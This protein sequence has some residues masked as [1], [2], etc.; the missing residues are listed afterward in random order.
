MVQLICCKDSTTGEYTEIPD[1]VYCGVS[2]LGPPSSCSTFTTAFALQWTGSGWASADNNSFQIKISIIECQAHS[3]MVFF[4]CRSSFKEEGGETCEVL[5]E[6]AGAS[7]FNFVVGFSAM[8]VS[9]NCC[10][11]IATYSIDG[12]VTPPPF[13]E[14][15]PFPP[16]CIPGPEVCCPPPGEG[17]NGGGEGGGG[18][19]GGNG[20]GGCGGFICTPA[21]RT[22][23]SA[24]VRYATGEMAINV[25]DLS[26]DGYGVPWGHTR[27]FANRQTASQ[28]IGNGFNWLVKEWPYL[29]KKFSIQDSGI[30]ID[31][32]V[33]QG[34][35]G[36]ALW[37]DNVG[38]NVFTPRFNVKDTFIHHES[39]NLYKLYKQDGSV[40]EF[41]DTT[42]M[43][44]RQTDPAGNKIEVTAMSVNSYN[45]TEVERTYTADGSTTNEQFLYNYDNSLGDY[46]LKDLT[47]R[48][49]VDTGSWTNISKVVYT[50]YGYDSLHGGWEDLETVTTQQWVNG[51]WNDTGT[52]YYRYYLEL[53]S[54]N[55]SSSSSSLSSSG[56][57]I[58]SPT[59]VRLL[60]Y[61]VEPAAYT[62]MEDDGVNPLTAS[63]AQ[64]ALYANYYFEYDA[65]RRVTKEMV[66][67]AS[68]TYL[69]SYEESGFSD[70]VNSWKTKTTE[71]LPD[72]SQNIIFSNS[73]GQTMLSV[74]KSGS[75][76]WNQFNKY[77]DTNQIVLIAN[78]SAITGYDETKADLLNEQAGNYQYMKDNDGL[79]HTFTYD[80]NSGFQTSD[81]IQKGELG[82]SIK[83]LEREYI[84]CGSD[85]SSSSSSSS[86]SGLAYFLSKEILYPS[87]TDQTKKIITSYAY[88]WYEGTCQV[89]EKTTTLPVIST[90]QNGSGVANTR[91]EYFDEY[92][93]LTWT[94]DERGYI[95]QSVYDIP[96]GALTQLVQ[97]VDTG[98]ASG[99]PTGWL[100]P[101][102][103]GLNLVT[104]F[105]HDDRGH[106]TQSLGPAHTIDLEGVATEI[107]TANW[108]V[109]KS[110]A[111]E[112]Q[113]T[114]A[115][116]YATGTLPSYTYTLINPVSISKTDKYGNSLERIQAT[117]ASTSGKLL[118]TDT[119][120][121]SSYVS[122]TTNQYT[123][124]CLLES[125]RAYH[126]IPASGTGSSGTNYD[127][128]DFGYD[129][130]KRQNRTRT[131]GGTI[132]F[133]VLDVRGNV[134]KT[135]I[136]TDDT[137]ATN[138]DPTG[139]GAVG[140]NM[141][142]VTELEY[143]GGTAGGDNNL[144]KQTQ[145]ASAS[146]TRITSFT[147]DW[148]NRNT[149][150]DGE[151]DHFQKKYY[152]NLNR[153]TKTELYNTTSAGNLI[154]RS[155]TKFDDL[156]RV[157]RTV[158]YGVDPSTGTVGNSLTS[159]TWYDA[160]GNVIKQLSA[161]SDLFIKK[162]YDSVG[163]VTNQ[164][165][166]YDLNET[167]YSDTSNVT[168]DTIIEQT[169][170]YYDDA[171]NVIKNITRQR[172][173]NAP[174][175]QKGEL[176]NPATTPKAR[177]N[178][179]AN[180][181]DGIGRSIVSANYGT[182]GGTTLSRSNTIPARSDNVLVVTQ[183]YNNAG[184][185]AR[186]TNPAGLVNKYEFDNIGRQTSVI[187]NYNEEISSSS[188]SSGGCEPSDEVNRTTRYTYTEDG[189]ESTIV[190]V[191]SI[192]GN[193]TTVYSYGI[194][195]SDSDIAMNTI[196]KSISY[197]DSTGGSDVVSY[198]YNRQQE[199][200]TIT[201]QRNCIHTFEYD[202]LGRLI[203]DRVTTTGTGVDDAVLRRSI[204]YDV[205]GL[206][207][208]LTTYDN[209]TVA[210][211]NIVNEIEN[212]FN[213]FG[214]LIESR[215]SHS[216][217]VTGLSPKVV[218]SYADGSN[219]TIRQTGIKY[220][221]GRELTYSYGLSG[222]MAD[223][224]SRAIKLIDDDLTT[225]IE[226]DYLGL[227]TFVVADDKEPDIK[228]TLVDLSS[229]NDVDTGDI[230]SGLD[231]FGRIKDCRWYDSGSSAD[232]VRIKYGH[233]RSSN[234]LWQ[235][236]I[237]AQTYNQNYDELFSYDGLNRLQAMRR[238]LLNN[239][240]S[241]M[242]TQDYDQC[243]GMDSTENWVT[244]KQ[245]NGGSTWTL[246]QNRI[247]NKV[248]EITNIS[249]T[250]GV[251][252][253]NPVFD[254]TGNM[255]TIPQSA[256]PG[257]SYTATWDAWDHLVKLVDDDTDNP[258]GEY[259]YDALGRRIVKQLFSSGV[260]DKTCHI[261]LSPTWQTVEERVDASSAPERQLVW[262]LQYIDDLVLRDRDTIGNGTLDERIYASYDANWNIVGLSNTNGS[263][264]Q[265]FAY[266]PYGKSNT[267]STNFTVVSDS[268]E[269]RY[270]FTSREGDS[271]SSL[272]YFRERYYH[273]QLGQFINRDPIEYQ[274]GN[275]L[276]AA[277][278]V[279]NKTD[280]F[281][282]SS[283][284]EIVSGFF[285]V[286]QGYARAG[287]RQCIRA[288]TRL[289]AG[290]VCIIG[291]VET[292]VRSCCIGT[293]K[294]ICNVT[295]IEIS[296]GYYVCSLISGSGGL[297]P[298][299]P[300]F[301]TSTP[302]KMGRKKK[303]KWVPK[304][305][306]S[307]VAGAHFSCP[308]EGLSG[309]VCITVSAG[310]STATVGA[311]GCYDF[312]SGNYTT[313][314]GYGI[315][316]GTGIAGS[317]SITLNLC[318]STKEC[319]TLF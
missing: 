119:F 291:C 173:H 40:I 278:F 20:P 253:T 143:D 38:N 223:A 163:R 168:N 77:N 296:V 79:I 27:S 72:G 149:D 269:W 212:V 289:G 213:N 60:K 271:E 45:F 191:N 178:F 181:Y 316:V 139:G 295:R 162:S 10:W 261:Y 274:D 313:D 55:S 275:N 104:D 208:V 319:C 58:G 260:I 3:G 246:E 100:T 103:G 228:W 44:R 87:D 121:Q 85:N 245:A 259:E 11:E 98:A 203:H 22:Y 135:F 113:T 310:F 4:E 78:S 177:V 92:G 195:L 184:L 297:T 285:D 81:S 6:Q 39:E 303:G 63:D 172:Y 300:A 106:I 305:P 230:Y 62:R 29:V 28:S 283:A 281:G 317:G 298:P 241:S 247:T 109:Y 31:T 243:W 133:N 284:S 15:V 198:T 70:G 17:P 131:P 96:T 120:A 111:D 126:T 110:N 123:E 65:Q 257:K 56:G 36:D 234:L 48:R 151:I 130:M 221:N 282:E 21:T 1:L 90:S 26:T 315:G 83:L 239:N 74:L 134:I 169:E 43:F 54:G 318:A 50:Y 154:E 270:R 265:R 233:D 116:G 80:P 288:C 35:V 13:G 37:Y 183:T 187:E 224:L 250:V 188:S 244:M 165:T 263:I 95:N 268:Y 235:E 67:G 286:V 93:Y 292:D 156:S 249:N 199:S 145:Y 127:Q 248:N 51:A 112:N 107:R 174:A 52:S 202:K 5:P 309:S 206:P 236:D 102:G 142:Q 201:D 266:E 229:V 293:F 69:F 46:L 152:D 2:L 114:Q 251:A 232:V 311:R 167:S 33:V 23:S 231:R 132:T 97:D 175:S 153:I 53:P 280:P 24:P 129:S 88:T 138:Q 276:Y 86:A 220:P 226:Y 258:I 136:G 101:S 222:S 256:D 306:G 185:I 215:Q 290:C 217:Q 99:V 141:V 254:L 12:T 166:G 118:S 75:D 71:T 179:V 49:K 147:Y 267:L 73:D 64:I 207:Q 32:I 192:T 240:K 299:F 314:V 170:A 105:E 160:A 61:V 25:T 8:P 115:R 42:G 117:R 137:G 264:I 204:S 34:V 308:K 9:E 193:Q 205:R 180:Y 19:P 255:K 66:E 59:R 301:K 211:G 14:P 159:N 140:N 273:N 194:T 125:T 89:K 219:N 287:A 144:T 171:S 214:Q 216:G 76:E 227:G 158:L 200:V 176:Q 210:Q 18:G 189:L 238:G 302:P 91:K 161:G 242:T 68:R 82:T 148:R 122:W 196:L 164:Y 312:G 279:P 7:C 146:D 272:I 155:E 225:L 84:S 209:A 252:W 237:V 94:M 108:F 197:P 304:R 157:Y 30:Q 41:D 124:C 186:I 57:A 277:Y 218:I 182:N 47:L 262:G 150:T 307:P 294:K 128:T 190:A 16:S